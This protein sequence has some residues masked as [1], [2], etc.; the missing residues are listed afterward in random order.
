[1]Q[2]SVLS[3]P[4]R[5]AGHAAALSVEKHLGPTASPTRHKQPACLTQQLRSRGP[6]SDTSLP[7][8]T[9]R[10]RT[11]VRPWEGCSGSAQ[12][13]PQRERQTPHIPG[14]HP[15]FAGSSYSLGARDL[16]TQSGG[17]WVILVLHLLG[18]PW[19]IFTLG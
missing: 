12:L 9:L 1:M 6:G 19:R 11:R 4:P 5:T 10:P 7:P 13:P 18:K 3:L 2:T 8:P 14:N 17:A 16:G 15:S